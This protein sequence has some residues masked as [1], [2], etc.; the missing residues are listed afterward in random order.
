MSRTKR[1]YTHTPS[2]YD[3]G[4]GISEGYDGIPIPVPNRKNKADSC[5]PGWSLDSVWRRKTKKWAKHVRGKHQRKDLDKTI[6]EQLSD[7]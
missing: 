1:Q 4:C 2:A 7:E 6:V 5:F 3:P